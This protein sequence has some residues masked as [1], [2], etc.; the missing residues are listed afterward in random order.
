[1]SEKLLSDE[2]RLPIDGPLL[3]PLMTIGEPTVNR[4]RSKIMALEAERDELKVKLKTI[5]RIGDAGR[6]I[7]NDWMGGK[8]ADELTAS[9]PAMDELHDALA[10]AQEE[11]E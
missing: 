4:W 2:M 10:A 1:M 5:E 7:Y 3:L 8:D 6:E 9:W 11:K